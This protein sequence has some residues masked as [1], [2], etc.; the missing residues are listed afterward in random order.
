MRLRISP[1]LKDTLEIETDGDGAAN[2][3]HKS[4]VSP[5]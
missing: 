3:E 2:G 5:Y 4:D 1:S